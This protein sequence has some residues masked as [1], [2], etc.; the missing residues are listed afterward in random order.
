[1]MLR[2]RG[3]TLIE[4]AVAVMITA[5]L[6]AMAY[7]TINQ[8]V[9][10]RT[11]IQENSA[12]LRAVQFTVRSM[13][14]DFSQLAPRPVREPIGSELQPALTTG[15]TEVAQVSLTRGGWMNP[16]GSERSTLQRVRY[17]LD[18]GK[19]LRE[20]WLVLDATLDP[21]PVRR[22]LLNGVT[23]FK[24]RFLDDARGWHDTWPPSS[25]STTRSEKDYRWR[26]TAVEVTI[27]LKDWGPIKRLIEVPG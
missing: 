11:R 9:G 14:Q 17:R 8:A 5:I 3:F 7:G 22:E 1:M 21:E 20:Y 2:Q 23:S 4:I 13:V 18:D 26:P 19:L 27:E 16:L 6:F 25:S 24:L 10:N 12:R 15:T